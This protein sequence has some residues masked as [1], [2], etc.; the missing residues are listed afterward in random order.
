MPRLRKILGDVKTFFVQPTQMNHC[1]RMT[2]LRGP[3]VPQEGSRQVFAHA[4]AVLE[5]T[6]E[7]VHCAR[8]TTIGRIQIVFYRI[9]LLVSQSKRSRKLEHKSRIARIG[10]KGQSAC[11]LRLRS[12]DFFGCWSFQ[13]DR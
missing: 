3:F 7:I 11:C 2:K 4:E 9:Q 5:H 10:S 8:M 6:A 12:L 13:V 1:P